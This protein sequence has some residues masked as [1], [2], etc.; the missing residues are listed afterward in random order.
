MKRVSLFF[1]CFLCCCTAAPLFAQ[2][3]D[4]L[5]AEFLSSM[6][7]KRYEEALA[8]AEQGHA[9]AQKQFG[10]ASKQ[11]YAS[12]GNLAVAH[13]TLQ[14][15]QKSIHY[16][17][18]LVQLELRR[19]AK[20]DVN[21]STALQMSLT[22]CDYHHDPRLASRAWKQIV[23][24]L[25]AVQSID[26][27]VYSDVPGY[28]SKASM[29]QGQATGAQALELLKNVQGIDL[30]LTAEQQAALA[31]YND[32][33]AGSQAEKRQA[34]AK[35]EP[36]SVQLARECARYRD[37]ANYTEAARS[38]EQLYM[39]RK[40]HEQTATNE[41]A[42]LCISLG[43]LYLYGY[44]YKQALRYLR[45]GVALW[46]QN[47]FPKNEK[48]IQALYSLATLLR[49]KQS[50]AEEKEVLL[51]A[52]SAAR[53][54]GWQK[55]QLYPALV[56]L[57]A[58]VSLRMGQY[59]KAETFFTQYKEL[60][61]SR[62]ETLP[63]LLVNYYL[64]V[65]LLY[66]QQGKWRQADEAYRFYNISVLRMVDHQF[67]YIALA[68]EK[69]LALAV[70]GYEYSQDYFYSYCRKR[71]REAA[72]LAGQMYNNELLAKGF[73]LRMLFR[74][75][76]QVYASQDQELIRDFERWAALRQQLTKL[77]A[78]PISERKADP[79][80]LGMELNRLEGILNSRLADQKQGGNFRVEWQSVQETLAPGEAA[81][82]F[83]KIEEGDP[84]K[85][86]S[87]KVFY[88]ALLL[89][90][91]RSQPQFVELFEEEEF[92][93]FIEETKAARSFEQVRRMYT[94]LPGK[95]GG[96]YK[97]DM[98]YRLL[99]EP[100]E[101]FL[102]GIET[103]YY[104][105]VGL[106]HK[107]SFNALPVAE[108]ET[109]INRYNLHLLSTTALLVDKQPVFHLSK[110][111]QIV[112]FGGILYDLDST[113][114]QGQAAAHRN[115]SSGLFIHDRSFGSGRGKVKGSPW[116]YLEGSL[117]E[118][119]QIQALLEENGRS[120]E[121]IVAEAAVEEYAKAEKAN[122]A[123]VMHIATHGFFLPPLYPK[124]RPGADSQVDPDEAF[125]RSGLLFA[126]ANTSWLGGVPPKGVED[127]I[128]TAYEISTLN[129]RDTKLVVLS[130][131]ETGLGDI[132]GGE[133]VYGLQRAFKLA[134]VE[135]LIMSLWQIP[136]AQ[137][138][139]LMKIFYTQWLAG[140]ELHDAFRT[141]QETLSAKYEPYFWGAFIL[142]D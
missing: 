103:I 104:S 14:S 126:G 19:I 15:W 2:S 35:Q 9:V 81:L 50:I 39:L 38:C 33:D 46:E 74:K 53:E 60:L 80:S 73:I 116:P 54:M 95:Y 18:E 101:P 13:Q 88:G 98:L 11:Y 107:I 4:E 117:T 34:A 22:S 25:A 51:K 10:P 77:E 123:E 70:D 84:I 55:V 76:E 100:L 83:V 45:E 125:K 136:D 43:E 37:Y 99:W 115:V 85:G 139:E 82:E 132:G 57:L 31:E 58:G 129:L 141:A 127:G 12:L 42:E 87:G 1:F 91:D 29:E 28:C 109:L 61:D 59:D 137:T 134:G 102:Q 118:V 130:A 93:R 90:A 36:A 62:Q 67:R 72:D 89:R 48:Y 71:Y 47:A 75:V 92:Q 79:G 133:G 5:E 27:S 23:T 131:C 113:I 111:E 121:L 20:I 6:E 140:Q 17:R 96:Q 21:M 124:K 106:L 94:W 105:P 78:L 138:A 119:K 64:G 86:W 122:H 8:V 40:K 30:A 66:T 26:F 56:E 7:G 110:E 65:G 68:S 49:Q 135:S 63:Q 114:L 142:L 128:L 41:F 97:G 44:H 108:K 112:L 16:F 120:T 69:K 32:L 3:W 24:R 52:E